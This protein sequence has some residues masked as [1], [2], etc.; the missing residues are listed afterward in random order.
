[1]ASSKVSAQERRKLPKFNSL[2]EEAMQEEA[3]REARDEKIGATEDQALAAQTKK[4]K[5]KEI[6]RIS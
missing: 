4:R 2:W 6:F 3:R 1:M 5:G